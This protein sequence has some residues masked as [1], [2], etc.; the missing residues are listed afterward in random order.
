MNG[1]MPRPDPEDEKKRAQQ[2]AQRQIEANRHA[3]RE[4]RRGLCDLLTFWKFCADARC[5]RARRCA[6]DVERCFNLFWPQVPD[7]IKNEIRHAIKLRSQGVP[8]QQA[9]DEAHE[10]VAQRKRIEQAA[11]AREAARRSAPPPVPTE[12]PRVTR[13]A[14]P[15]HRRGPRVR[16]L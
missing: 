2:E 10:F 14:P 15:G 6:G 16:G 13:N 11:L 12:P 1:K 3:E 9:A 7:D 4:R 8:P 5:K